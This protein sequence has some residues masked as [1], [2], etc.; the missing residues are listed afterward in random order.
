MKQSAIILFLLIFSLAGNVSQG[1]PKNQIQHD[2]FLSMNGLVNV[3]NT[4]SFQTNLFDF[5]DLNDLDGFICVFI[6]PYTPDIYHHDKL[7][8]IVDYLPQKLL[9]RA[10]ELVLD[11]PPPSL[12]V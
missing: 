5:Q 11:L 12:S 9:M 4:E 6:L 3:P 1:S 10:N 8:F 7:N 2:S